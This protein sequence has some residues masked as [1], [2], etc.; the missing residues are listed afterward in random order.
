MHLICVSSAIFSEEEEK[1]FNLLC[2][3]N[4][5]SFLTMKWSVLEK[6]FT[7]HKENLTKFLQSVLNT[8]KSFWL[9]YETFYDLPLSIIIREAPHILIPQ[10]L[11]YLTFYNA[12]FFA[13]CKNRV[14]RSQ[15]FHSGCGYTL[16]NE[17]YQKNSVLNLWHISFVLY[18]LQILSTLFQNGAI[19]NL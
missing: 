19:V 2:F 15:S 17:E 3:K 12:T 6:T 11:K 1:N 14:K 18:L 7:N 10:D 13:S 16:M 9:V 4:C 5:K 8:Q